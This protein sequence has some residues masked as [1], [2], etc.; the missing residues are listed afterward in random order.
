MRIH[1]G[2]STEEASSSEKIETSDQYQHGQRSLGR[3][4]ETKCLVIVPAEIDIDESL[5]SRAS[6]D[7]RRSMTRTNPVLFIDFALRRRLF[8]A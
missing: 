8:L 5:D 1:R 2:S 6:S 7:D 4:R 3:S